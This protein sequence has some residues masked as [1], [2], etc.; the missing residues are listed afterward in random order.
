MIPLTGNVSLLRQAD[1]FHACIVFRSIGATFLIAAAESGFANQL[2][3]RLTTTA[4]NV[5][6]AIVTATSATKLRDQYT[7][8]KLDGVLRAYAW[9]IQV[10]FA[11]TI[12]TC[13]LSVVFSLFTR[14]DNVNAKKA[15]MVAK[16][17][18]ATA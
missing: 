16:I 6:P 14:W 7:G 18:K 13:G 15:E 1:R 5:D 11:I 12:A 10:A 17:K 4:P 9:G 2:V 8:A 3:A